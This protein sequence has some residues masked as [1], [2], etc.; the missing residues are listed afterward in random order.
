[1]SSFFLLFLHNLSRTQ[2]KVGIKLSC[3]ISEPLIENQDEK[4]FVFPSYPH[5]LSCFAVVFL[6]TGIL[7]DEATAVWLLSTYLIDKLFFL[8][9]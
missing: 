5:S 2:K 7:L 3:L 1:M 4:S 8:L 6:I 9:F